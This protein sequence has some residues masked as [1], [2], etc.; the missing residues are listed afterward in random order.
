MKLRKILFS[1]MMHMILQEY[2]ILIKMAS[3][4]LTQ[5]LYQ[6]SMQ[7]ENGLMI[8]SIKGVHIFLRHQLN[9]QIG[10]SN[11]DILRRR[12]VFG[13]EPICVTRLKVF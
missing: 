9:G 12:F 3:H 10:K 6:L 8:D 2:I 1:L 13:I 5:N 11:G 7:Q 4:M